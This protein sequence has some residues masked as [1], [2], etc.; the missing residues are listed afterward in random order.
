MGQATLDDDDLFGEAADE[1]R[2]DVIGHLDAAEAALPDPDA[3]WSAE[4]GNVLGVLNTLRSNLEV[5]E[6][7]EALRQA[8]KWYSL[9]ERADAFEGE[10]ELGDRMDALEETVE[11]L[12]DM[13][14][15]VA[16]VASTLPE[17]RERLEEQEP[18][19]T[20]AMAAN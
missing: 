15:D 16:G 7:T 8:R 2:E 17:L 10:T 9:G 5:D 11:Q 6:A 14:A 20:S 18:A 13:Q 4:A 1:L 19:D 3:I 12:Q